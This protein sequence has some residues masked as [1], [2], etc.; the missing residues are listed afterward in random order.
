MRQEA[1]AVDEDVVEDLI[2][3]SDEDGSISDAP[4]NE[5]GSMSEHSQSDSEDENSKPV[6]LRGHSKKQKSANLSEKRR[7]KPSNVTKKNVRSG[8][9]TSRKRKRSGKM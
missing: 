2:L 3:S 8:R 7:Q 6:L 9:K 5:D 1:E 4:S